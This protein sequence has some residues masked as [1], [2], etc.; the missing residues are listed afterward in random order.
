MYW[1]SDA[2]DEDEPSG[3]TI[4]TDK[5]ME[6]QEDGEIVGADSSQPK[7]KMSVEFPGINAPIPEKADER[8]WAARVGPPSSSDISKNWSQ[9][10][11]SSYGSRGHHREQRTGDFR[12]DGPPGDPGHS[13][14]QFSFQSRFGGGHV[15]PNSMA[16]WSSRRSPLYEEESPKP[17]SFHSLHYSN[18]ERHFLPFERDSG[19]RH[20]NWSSGSMHDRDRDKDLS[21]RFNDRWS[22]SEDRHYHSRR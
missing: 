3:I 22:A 6:E 1:N 5:D 14:S 8:L 10:R 12:D 18:S 11:S 21:S 16:E 17:F 2:D 19:G 4:F 9:Q 7:R 15:S 20:G 13:S